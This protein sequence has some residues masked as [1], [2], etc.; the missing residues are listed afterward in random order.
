VHRIYG[1][2]VDKNGDPIAIQRIAYALRMLKEEIGK[3]LKWEIRRSSNNIGL[4]SFQHWGLKFSFR[5]IWSI[6]TSILA[7]TSGFLTRKRPVKIG[8]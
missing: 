3:T 1:R 6:R 4:R 2:R 7:F 5:C 8:L